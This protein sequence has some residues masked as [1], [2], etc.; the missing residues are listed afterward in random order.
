MASQALDAVIEQLRS[1]SLPADAPV[2]VLRGAY[3]ELPPGDGVTATP[4]EVAGVGAEWVVAPESSPGRR[5]LYLHGGGYVICSPGTHRDL[6]SRLARASGASVLVLDYSLAPETPYPAAVDE[7]VAA[8]AWMTENGPQGAASADVTLIAGDSAGGGLSVATLVATRDAGGALP[9][10]AAL[11]S[12]WT[13]LTLS[14]ES[15]RTR[16]EADPM[17]TEALIRRMAA[18][19]LQG[20]DPRSPLA[21][22]LYA[23]LG[24]LP[25]LLLH[26][27]DAEVLLDDTLRLARRAEEAG[28]EVTV[29]VFPELIHIFHFFAAVL[30]EGQEA[31]HKVGQFFHAHAGDNAPNGSQ[32]P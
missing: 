16:A 29:E 25:P 14:G 1:N 13:D 7:A 12:P 2:D 28:V 22:P 6:T 8:L 9:A 30:P 18:D 24:G 17:V 21:S 26:A 32:N 11:I 15:M 3:P 23:D 19:Y 4:V 5:L 10:A 31:I 20:S 27:G